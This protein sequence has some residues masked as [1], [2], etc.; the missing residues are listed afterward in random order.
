MRRAHICSGMCTGRLS[1]WA[2][3]SR[4]ASG[5][6]PTSTRIWPPRTRAMVEASDRV[7]W[8]V[9]DSEVAALFLEYALIKEHLPRFN[10]RLRD[11]KSYPYLALTVT[12]EWPRA[13]VMRGAK[14]PGTRYFGPYAHA[15]AIRNT[16]DLLLKSLPIRT[17]FGHGVPP[18]PAQ[19]PPVHR[20]RHRAL[21]GALRGVRRAA[22]LHRIRDRP[23]A[24]AD[25]RRGAP[26]HPPAGADARVLRP[27]GIRT[28]GPPP[29][30]DPRRAQG[31][32]PPGGGEA[33][34]RKT[35]T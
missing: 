4:C 29:G 17:L 24:G 10:I 32:G 13:R 19:G 33:S 35:S 31:G 20:I 9:V 7:E 30:P 1:T 21:L 6:L 2:R 25:R 3:P 15:Y 34:G 23:R 14:K 12:D 16:L 22:C 26:H 8:I 18:P 27:V 11:D 5:W 28:G